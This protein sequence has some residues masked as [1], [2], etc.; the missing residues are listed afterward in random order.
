MYAKVWR[1]TR[2]VGVVAAWMEDT[3]CHDGLDSL[4]VNLR[5][6]LAPAQFFAK[7]PG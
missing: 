1:E 6:L 7:K 4:I 3:A 5:A 2:S